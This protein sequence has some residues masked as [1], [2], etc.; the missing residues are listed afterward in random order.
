MEILANNIP[1]SRI[2]LTIKS[3]RTRSTGVIR[4]VNHFM[5]L[6]KS[7]KPRESSIVSIR[8]QRRDVILHENSERG[9][10]GGIKL[11]TKV[12]YPVRSNAIQVGKIRAIILPNR[13]TKRELPS[14]FNR[15]LEKGRITVSLFQP[16]LSGLLS[17]TRLLLSQNHSVPGS[18]ISISGISGVRVHQVKLELSLMQS[19]LGSF[20]FEMDIPEGSRIPLNKRV[21]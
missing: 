14:L 10:L 13:G 18:S 20:H 4:F 21:L 11:S 9:A 17:P 15:R 6:L 19:V 16:L 2:E 3:V 5:N 8:N 12:I 1:T 7:G